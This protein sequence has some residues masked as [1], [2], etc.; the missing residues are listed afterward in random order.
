MRQRDIKRL[1]RGKFRGPVLRSTGPVAMAAV[2]AGVS[3]RSL[4]PRFGVT[5]SAV[6]MWDSRK[7]APEAV[8]AVLAAEPF[9]VP[10]SAWS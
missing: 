3:M 7:S 2:R 4:A 9:C 6:K 1:R 10:L 5:Y 8:R